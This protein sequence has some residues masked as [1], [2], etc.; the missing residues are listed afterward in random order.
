[1]LVPIQAKSV[2]VLYTTWSA[3]EEGQ[4]N[5]WKEHDAPT[6]GPYQLPLSRRPCV[7]SLRRVCVSKLCGLQPRRSRRPHGRLVARLHTC[8]NHPFQ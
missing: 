6:H 1:M 5:T 3:Q 8:P 7:L 4:G 2:F